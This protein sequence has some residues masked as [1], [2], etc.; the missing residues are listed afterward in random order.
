ME[1]LI[2]S[3]EDEIENLNKLWKWIK[4]LDSFSGLKEST[5]KEMQAKISSRIAFCERSIIDNSKTNQH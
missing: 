1:Q 4:E 5:M 2:K 3:R